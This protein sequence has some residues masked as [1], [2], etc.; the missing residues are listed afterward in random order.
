M[1][2]KPVENGSDGIE[3]EGWAKTFDPFVTAAPVSLGLRVRQIWCADEERLAV[4]FEFSP[5]QYNHVVWEQ[6]A[7]IREGFQC[8]QQGP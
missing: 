6:L 4:I 2:V 1:Q 3:F 7:A 8:R 5:Q